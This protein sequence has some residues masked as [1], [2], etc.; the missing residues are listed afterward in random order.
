MSIDS[1]TS[2][3]WQNFRRSWTIQVRV[4]YALILRETL[5]RYGR[6]NI[7]FLWLFAEPMLFTVGVTILW[8]ATRS[9]HGSS[10]PIA[11]FALT[12]YS[13]VLLWR[14]MPS[15]CIGSLA[16]NLS[17]LYHRNVRPL[18]I[19]LS[20]LILE[21]AGATMSLVFL[22]LFFYFVGWIE[23]PENVLQ[24]VGGWIMLTWF[25]FAL[26]LFL[27]ALSEASE[28]VEKLWHPAAY[29]MFPLSGAAFLL[30]SLPQN[31]R[32]ILLYLPMVHG[33]EYL[34][35]G[36]FGSRIVAHYDMGYMAMVN[37][38]LSLLGLAKV[39]QISRF[40]IPE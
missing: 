29:F 30:D 34:R 31:A 9:V 3:P 26:A 37:T 19:Y 6:H 27:G 16:P 23:L 22:S 39:R 4:I 7:G 24:V 10:L 14:N 35:E 15:R 36:W 8:T 25:G 18:D 11:A 40:V 21:P 32:D 1:L 2:S 5:T 33:V 20:R 17:L 12:G 38:A 28:T 13:S